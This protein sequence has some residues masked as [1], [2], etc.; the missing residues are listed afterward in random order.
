MPVGTGVM[1]VEKPNIWPLGN[2]QLPVQ[3]SVDSLGAAMVDVTCNK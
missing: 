3:F 2:S 1:L